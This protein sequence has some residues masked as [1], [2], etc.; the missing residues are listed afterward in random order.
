M[1]ACD[2]QQAHG[3]LGHAHSS[4]S[5]FTL[6][7]IQTLQLDLQID[8]ALNRDDVQARAAMLSFPY[9]GTAICVCLPHAV[10]RAAGIA[11]RKPRRSIN[12]ALRDATLITRARGGWSAAGF[13]STS[14]PAA[15]AE[16]A[17][18]SQSCPSLQYACPLRCESAIC[19]CEARRPTGGSHGRAAQRRAV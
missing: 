17:C 3:A 7:A 9:P 6:R 4:C 10:I 2:A 8:T 14:I 11:G 19:A 18:Q 16:K 12:R 13:M 1:D 5:C 15:V